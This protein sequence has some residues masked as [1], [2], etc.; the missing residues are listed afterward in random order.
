MDSAQV[1]LPVYARTIGVELDGWDGERP[2][3][4]IDYTN[5]ICGNPGMFHGGAVSSLLEMAAVATLRAGVEDGAG[6]VTANA[7]VEFLRVAAEQRAYASA[8]IVRA[9]RRLATVQ[10]TLWQESPEKP[11]A[12][13]IFNIMIEAAGGR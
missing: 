7:T 1:E 5:D 2:I 9:G 12:T 13:A 8:K 6:L 4:A 10:A 11:V 3:L